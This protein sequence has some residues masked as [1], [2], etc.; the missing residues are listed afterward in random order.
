MGGEGSGEGS[1][2][3]SNI[4]APITR[5]IKRRR[6][7]K[8]HGMGETERLF[9]GVSKKGGCLQLCIFS[10]WERQTDCIIAFTSHYSISPVHPVFTCISLPGFI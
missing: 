8:G 9:K 6:G 4:N 7:E 5:H 1:G 3:I 2:Y 10:S